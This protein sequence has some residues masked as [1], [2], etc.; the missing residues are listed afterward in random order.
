MYQFGGLNLY[1][2][3]ADIY[4][5]V[6]GNHTKMNYVAYIYTSSYIVSLQKWYDFV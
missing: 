1:T 2:Q 3:Q 4:E 5:I 6:W